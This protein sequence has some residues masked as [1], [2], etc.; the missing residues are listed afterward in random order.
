MVSLK[1]ESSPDRV[2]NKALANKAEPPSGFCGLITC[3]WVFFPK[4]PTHAN[5]P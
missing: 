2:I 4:L 5:K 1:V 3:R